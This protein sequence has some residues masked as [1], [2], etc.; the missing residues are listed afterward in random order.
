MCIFSKRKFIT[1]KIF[2]CN[3]FLSNQVVC[4]GHYTVEYPC[5]QCYYSKEQLCFGAG[6]CD[7]LPDRLWENIPVHPHQLLCTWERGN[8][9]WA[10]VN[11]LK[12][13]GTLQIEYECASYCVKYS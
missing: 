11:E 9:K 12:Q 3:T 10:I 1:Q 8:G 4:C 2:S 6:L 7:Q 13:S 5:T